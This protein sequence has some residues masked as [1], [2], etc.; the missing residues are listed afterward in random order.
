MFCSNCCRQVAEQVWR[1]E[2]RVLIDGSFEAYFSRRQ[3]T[4]LTILFERLGRPVDREF[5]ISRIWDDERDIEVNSYKGLQVNICL[6]RKKL[7]GSRFILRHVQS[8]G[9]MLE[10]DDGSRSR[11]I[12]AASPY[13]RRGAHADDDRSDCGIIS[14]G[15]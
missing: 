3:G 12:R 7:K 6:I 11:D 8:Y 1:K 10:I 9:Y 5:I 13:H 14:A 15:D 4:I 2:D